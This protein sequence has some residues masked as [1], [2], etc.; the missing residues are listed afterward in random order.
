MVGVLTLCGDGFLIVRKMGMMKCDVC[1]S[2]GF[3]GDSSCVVGLNESV[4]PCV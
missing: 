4:H 2:V 1:K 3:V